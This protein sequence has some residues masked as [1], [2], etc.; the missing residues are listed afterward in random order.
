[1]EFKVA[2]RK[3]L[4]TPKPG[5]KVKIA[6]MNKLLATV[7]TVLMAVAATSS[8]AHV[9]LQKSE[10]ENGSTLT[11]SP[12][13]LKFHYNGPVELAMSSVKLLGVAD[14][15]VQIGK[16]VL[17]D[18]DPKTLVVPVP[19]LPAGDYRFEWSTVGHDGH[20]MKGEVRF[21]VK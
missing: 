18:G 4:A 10:P 12:T 15:A 7:A 13:V 14:P 19:R 5:D 17:A 6:T 11:A 20:P 16:P 3:M 21:T 1:M 8:F 9:K 2:D